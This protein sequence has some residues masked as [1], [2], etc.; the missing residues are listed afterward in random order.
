MFAGSIAAGY[1]NLGKFN[2][3]VFR[4]LNVF[5]ASMTDVMISHAGLTT[6]VDTRGRN[7]QTPTRC[8]P[9]IVSNDSS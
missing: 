5:N 2:Y 9:C 1:I 6:S 8:H 3:G 4:S 7:R